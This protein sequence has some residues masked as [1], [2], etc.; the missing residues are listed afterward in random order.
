VVETVPFD[1]ILSFA[2]GLAVVWTA[3]VQIAGGQALPYF[4]MGFAFQALVF[5][6]IGAWLYANHPD[7]SW[8]YLLDPSGLPAWAGVVAVGG[9]AGGF[10]VG[11]AVGLGLLRAGRTGTLPY[12][13]ASCGAILLGYFAVL[14]RSFWWVG[15]Y[16]QFHGGPAETGMTALPWSDLGR[17]LFL[18]GPVF[19]GGLAGIL[20]WL[21][22]QGRRRSAEVVPA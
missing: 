4:G 14:A 8:N 22:K 1:V 21:E 17:F 9:Y 20:V 3:R 13:I 7:W 12:L 16:A 15:T 18:V 11:F 2:V 5:C 10:V 6:P 19:V